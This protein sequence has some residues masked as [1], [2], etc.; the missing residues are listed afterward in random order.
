MLEAE[1][2]KQKLRE[3]MRLDDT[4]DALSTVQLR[5]FFRETLERAGVWK[6][7]YVSGD[8]YGTAFNEGERSIGLWLLAKLDE[9][10][11]EKFA[12]MMEEKRQEEENFQ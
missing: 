1:E 11:P 4:R 5:R 7:S 8:P 9:A 12:V 10:A 6:R 2:K 3:Q